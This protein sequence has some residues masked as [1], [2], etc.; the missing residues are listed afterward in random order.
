MKLS[1]SIKIQISHLICRNRKKASRPA[2]ALPYELDVEG[3]LSADKSF[4]LISM[5]VGN[6]YF[7][8]QSAGC[9]FTIYSYGKEFKT[10]NYAVAAG[11][12]LFDKTLLTEF[13]NDNYDIRLYGPNGFYRSFKG[14]KN[15][16]PILISFFEDSNYNADK[17]TYE[18]YRAH[19]D[20]IY[21]S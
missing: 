6:L 19:F 5:V 21:K 16:P 15:D 2:C 13:E 20:E 3:E 10:K 12:Q 4:F 1:R 18:L 17:K 11:D 14:N 7:E 9:P 8:D